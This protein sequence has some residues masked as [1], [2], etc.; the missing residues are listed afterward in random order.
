[1]VTFVVVVVLWLVVGFLGMLGGNGDGTNWCM[2]AFM[3]FAPV[4]PIIASLCGMI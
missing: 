2:I 1:M 3:T 4:L